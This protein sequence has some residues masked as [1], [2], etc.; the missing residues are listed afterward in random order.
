M[1]ALGA[2]LA[3]GLL[4]CETLPTHIDGRKVV[5]MRYVDGR[6]VYVVESRQG[7]RVEVI[8]I[9]AES[10]RAAKGIVFEGAR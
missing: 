5:G 2:L 1:L 10:A 9:A 8:E 3:V 4:G 6:R 7:D